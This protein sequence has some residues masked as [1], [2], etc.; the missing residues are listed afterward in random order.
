LFAAPPP[1]GPFDRF[2]PIFSP[3]ANGLFFFF[4]YF[5]LF[6]CQGW[7]FFTESPF[8]VLFRFGAT[9]LE[10][11]GTGPGSPSLVI[12]FDKLPSSLDFLVFLWGQKVTYF[13][14]L[15]PAPP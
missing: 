9:L 13:K 6:F 1:T 11:K 3:F 12:R 4:C 5:S 7:P 15:H 10:A 8:L 2:W 14:F